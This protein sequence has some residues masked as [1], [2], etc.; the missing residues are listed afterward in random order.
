MPVGTNVPT[1]A[2]ARIRL[3]MLS[4]CGTRRYFE[5]TVTACRATLFRL[6][7]ARDLRWWEARPS[8]RGRPYLQ[9]L[10]CCLKR[11]PPRTCNTLRSP[12][13]TLSR[14]YPEYRL[15]G[16]RI[17]PHDR[18][19]LRE[20]VPFQ[21]GIR[22]GFCHGIALEGAVPTGEGRDEA[23]VE[24][25]R[26]G[27]SWRGPACRCRSGF[28]IASGGGG[29]TRRALPATRAGRGIRVGRGPPD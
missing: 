16:R 3:R 2:S 29:T 28:S 1:T 11:V 14:P 24:S 6:V 15:P 4:R 22:L 18:I 10:A 21:R 17:S 7:K 25:R 5:T 20:C 26:I 13:V 23:E 27:A 9:A 8:G 19:P 12:L